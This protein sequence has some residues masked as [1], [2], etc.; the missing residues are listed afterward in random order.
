[1][2]DIVA[3]FDRRAVGEQQSRAVSEA[4]TGSPVQ[5]RVAIGVAH[6]DQRTGIEKQTNTI[7]MPPIG[8]SMQRRAAFGV[9]P[10]DRR[11]VAPTYSLVQSSH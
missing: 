1:M 3:R 9:A 2:A 7:S 5:R 11:T 10:V 6:V 4:P 8:R